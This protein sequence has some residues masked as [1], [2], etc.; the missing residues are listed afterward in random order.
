MK[1]NVSP[2]SIMTLNAIKLKMII[3]MMTLS[4][5]SLKK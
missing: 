2:Y 1:L 5:M 3:G 4:K